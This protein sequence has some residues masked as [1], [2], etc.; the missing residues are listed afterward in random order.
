M[1]P[2]ELRDI[3][4]KLERLER[5]ERSLSAYRQDRADRP[6]NEIEP[7]EETLGRILA[8]YYQ[9]RELLLEVVPAHG[10]H[11]DDWMRIMHRQP[12]AITG[13]L[14]SWLLCA[15]CG[16]SKRKH[17]TTGKCLYEPTSFALDV[18]ERR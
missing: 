2:A 15:H 9:M 4:D 13:L 3:A 10:V 12:L 18:R 14:E 8:E 17:A 7:P 16:V 6:K 1:T 11:R 5:M